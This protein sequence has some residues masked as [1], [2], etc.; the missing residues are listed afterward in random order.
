MPCLSQV[1]SVSMTTF[2]EL[3][4]FLRYYPS[5]AHGRLI[6]TEFKDRY[7][8]MAA[9]MANTTLDGTMRSDQPWEPGCTRIVPQA[10]KTCSF[11]PE[12]ASRYMGLYAR[13]HLPAQPRFSELIW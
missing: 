1:A 11:Q 5:S 2:Q 10:V 7:S 4:A 3:H 12:A 9:V 8:S 13:R 6:G